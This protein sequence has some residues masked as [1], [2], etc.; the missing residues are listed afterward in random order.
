MQR[1]DSVM[2]SKQKRARLDSSARRTSTRVTYTAALFSAIS[3]ELSTCDT[4]GESCGRNMWQDVET[5]ASTRMNQKASRVRVCS[6]VEREKYEYIST[7]ARKRFASTYNPDAR[8]LSARA[9]A[10]LHTH[11]YALYDSRLQ[12]A[13]RRRLRIFVRCGLMG[14]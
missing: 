14:N 3:V 11:F 13:R 2:A 12:N 8:R 4:C 6:T 5:M 10:D 9:L 7:K 1:R